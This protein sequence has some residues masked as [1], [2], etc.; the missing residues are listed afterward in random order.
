MI[1]VV[2]T[3]EGVAA[4]ALISEGINV[5]IT[6]MFSL[7]HYEVVANAYL[8][9]LERCREPTKVASVGIF[10]REPRGYGCGPSIGRNRHGRCA[11]PAW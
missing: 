10:L 4:S 2:A 11:G 7:R 1:K 5:N 8:R 6:L 3:S 9:G